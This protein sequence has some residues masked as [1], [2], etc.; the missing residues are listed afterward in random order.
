MPRHMNRALVTLTLLLVPT[1]TLAGVALPAASFACP[2]GL[3]VSV[4][5]GQKGYSETGDSWA[6]WGSSGQAIGADYRYLSKYAGAPGAK[7]KATWKPDVPVAGQYRVQATFRATENRTS[8]ADY[9]VIGADG[10][11][12]H[13]VVDQRDGAQNGASHGPVYADLGVHPFAPG[14]GHV[15]LDGTDD[16]GSDE[17]DA[18]VLELISCEGVVEPPPGQCTPGEGSGPGVAVGFAA[19]VPAATGWETTSNATGAPDGSHA[20]NPNLESG[21]ALVAKGFAVC[22][23]EGSAAAI[24]S[25][26][27][28]VRTK[29]QYASGKYAVVLGFSSAGQSATFAHEALG[30]DEVDVT[31]TKAAWTFD[32]VAALTAKLSLHEH[33]GG[34]IDSDV[35]VDAFRVTVGYSACA[36]QVGKVCKDGQLSWVDGCGAVGAV[37]DACDDGNA[38]TDDGCLGDACTHAPSA[39]PECQGCAPKAGKGCHASAVVWLDSCG[40]PTEIAESCEDADPCTVDACD[41]QSATCTHTPSSLPECQGCAPSAATVCLSG[42]VVWIDA[43]GN[44]EGVAVA[45]DDGDP[46]TTDACDPAAQACTHTPVDGAGCEGALP[47]SRLPSIACQGGNLM[48][49][50]PCGRVVGVSTPCADSDPCTVDGCDE[51]TVSCVHGQVEEGGCSAPLPETDAGS[52][53][54]AVDAGAQPAFDTGTW[55]PPEEPTAIA[56]DPSDGC[57]AGHGRGSPAL[58]LLLVAIAARRTWCR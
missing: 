54:P 22:A 14:Q 32:D 9:Y 12:S 27:V 39:A 15:L 57:S 13:T 4:D 53:P 30:W 40:L 1:S 55:A 24:T 50:D 56:G 17:A 41:P 6:T 49:L 43:C 46:C 33:P 48:R 21:E 2:V 11:K 52:V 23:P 44:P 16:S 58:L 5:N 18:V 28:G 26:K 34:A 51:G 47:C 3:T 38:C 7:G 35:W 37:A 45:C 20:F 10:A 29:V 36:P 25:V 42:D 8:D 31:V 19:S